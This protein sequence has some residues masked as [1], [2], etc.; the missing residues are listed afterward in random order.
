M[1]FDTP[2]FTAVCNRAA[3]GMITALLLVGSARTASAQPVGGLPLHPQ[4]SAAAGGGDE[5]SP[6][7]NKTVQTSDPADERLG[8]LHIGPTGYTTGPGGGLDLELTRNNDVPSLPPLPKAAPS[9]SVDPHDLQGSW[10]GEQFLPSFE[11]RQDMYGNKIPF[12]AAG[13]K[14]MDRRLLATDNRQSYMTPA[15]T[16]RQSGPDWDMI[17]IPFRIYQ[18]KNRID[19]FS[20]MDRMWWPIAL[21]P[22]VLPPPLSKNTYM[23]RS[24]GHWEG[25]TLVVETSSFKN[26][27]WLSFRGTPVSPSGKLI[28]HIRKLHDDD[29][30]YIEIVTTVDDPA[31]Y[32]KPWKFLRSYEWRPDLSTVSE[33]DCEEQADNNDSGATPE[34]ND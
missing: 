1:T 19:I 31:Y 24:I 25:D 11:I 18:S 20:T 22:S 28:Y 14:V 17:F 23:G 2:P 8:G 34:P 13:R 12:T 5:K 9:P 32:T 16:C 26:R 3:L 30:W 6:L 10:F 27:R 7:G 33:Y 15:F 29:H 4:P 21:D